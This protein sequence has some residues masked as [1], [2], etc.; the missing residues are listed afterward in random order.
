LTGA[1]NQSSFSITGSGNIKA[2]DYLVQ[3]VNCKIIGSGNIETLV[4]NSL[5]ANVVGSG[6]ISYRGEPKSINRNITGSGK[7]KAVD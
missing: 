6:D 2:F 5:D 7:L 1:S 4:I 3:E